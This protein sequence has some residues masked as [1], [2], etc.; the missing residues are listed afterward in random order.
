MAKKAFIFT[1]FTKER[2]SCNEMIDI[3]EKSDQKEAAELLKKYNS[4]PPFMPESDEIELKVISATVL[5]ETSKIL[6]MSKRPR[7]KCV[8]INNVTE[9]LSKES[10]RFKNIFEQLFFEVILYENLSASQMETELENISQIAKDSLIVMII[11]HGH[12][13]KVTGFDGNDLNIADIV[14]IFSEK[15]CLALK[16]K[17]KLFFFNCCRISEP[18]LLINNFSEFFLNTKNK[19]III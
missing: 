14:D 12:D 13:E 1:E 5:R 6:P 19:I 4:S 17:P 9:V 11:S 18:F 8:I 10:L 16:R 7:G 15:K 3:L 2:E